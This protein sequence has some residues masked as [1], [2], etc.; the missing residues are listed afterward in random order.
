MLS[1]TVSIPPSVSNSI[2][3]A[4]AKTAFA[5]ATV[6]VIINQVFAL[7][8]PCG[9]KPASGLSTAAKVGI[10]VGAGVGGLLLLGF[11]LF[12][13][14]RIGKR[15]LQK[16]QPPPPIDTTYRQPQAKHMS[17]STAA[18]SSPAS[19]GS[20]YLGQASPQFHPQSDSYGFPARS[21]LSG[22]QSHGSWSM[23]PVVNNSPRYRTPVEMHAPQAYEIGDDNR[24]VNSDLPGMI[25]SGGSN[26]HNSSYSA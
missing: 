5:T 24:T 4:V 26:A 25:S 14:T 12:V 23:Q 16:R 20:S 1:T 10:G 3:S 8:L 2:S 22:M 19:M 13:L 21:A 6:S 7:G 9:D 18:M 17:A 15:R 11:I